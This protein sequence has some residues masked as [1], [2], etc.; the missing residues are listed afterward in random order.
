[1][2]AFLPS[3]PM[4]DFFIHPT[5]NAR[6]RPRPIMTDPYPLPFH[7]AMSPSEHGDWLHAVEKKLSLQRQASMAHLELEPA[8]WYGYASDEEPASPSD[9]DVSLHD[10]EDALSFP[11]HLASSCK[12]AQQ[13]CKRAQAVRIRA[14]GKP[15][16]V[17]LSKTPESPTE[18]RSTQKARPVTMHVSRQRSRPVIPRLL[19]IDEIPSLRSSSDSQ[20]ESVGSSPGVHSPASTAPSSISEH[21]TQLHSKKAVPRH[22]P[23]AEAVQKPSPQNSS[24][25]QPL[26]VNKLRR[27]SLTSSIRSDSPTSP[28]KPAIRRIS[29][30]PSTFTLHKNA[31]RSVAHQAETVEPVPTS[32]ALEAPQVRPPTRSTSLKNRMVARGANERE[33]TLKLP[34]FPDDIQTTWPSRIDSRSQGE[35]GT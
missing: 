29:K 14:A 5:C 9:E 2:A 17:S 27:Q 4:E 32:A 16:V 30:L 19:S 6:P 10:G 13:Q 8:L 18:P 11:E 25:T 20:A 1:M 34:P 23:L 12:D 15:K 3:R 28:L 7:A 22:I 35:V 26:F 31:K 21:Q 24:Q 33:P